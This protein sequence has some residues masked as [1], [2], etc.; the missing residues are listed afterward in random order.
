MFW[1]RYESAF[2][3]ATCG[4]TQMVAGCDCRGGPEDELDE[5]PL[6]VFK[7]SA[8]NAAPLQKQQ[9]DEAEAAQKAA[10]E[11][12]K[13]KQEARAAEQAARDA[14]AARKQKE[15]AASQQKAEAASA[16]E[17]PKTEEK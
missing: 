1:S 17:A 5:E 10:E 16:D 3:V 6:Q 4:G 2:V 11:A 13:A 9:A 7:G 14:E 15:E 12:E 8:L